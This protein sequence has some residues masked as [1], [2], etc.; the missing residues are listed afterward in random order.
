[1]LRTAAALE[2]CEEHL[3]E[4]GAFATAIESYLT[5]YVL[6]V[7]CAEIQSEIYEVMRRRAA[8]TSDAVLGNYAVQSSQRVL[9]S[10]KTNELSGFAKLFGQEV[11]ERFQ[12]ALDDRDVSL[13]NSAVVNRHDIA[14][15]KGAEITFREV[16][17]A[18]EAATRI[19]CSFEK[20]L[21]SE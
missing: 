12:N 1:M 2:D 13:Y 16:R 4:S 6:I 18:V 11:K 3:R 17:E 20:A 15:K 7:F 21:D 19:L 8:M 9:R 14:H 10:V 5:Q